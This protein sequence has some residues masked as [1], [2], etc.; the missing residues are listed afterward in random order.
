MNEAGATAVLAKAKKDLKV[1]ADALK[2]VTKADKEKKD[3]KEA[4]KKAADKKA[5]DEKAAADAKVADW[6]CE[7]CDHMNKADATKCAGCGAPRKK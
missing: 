4:D 2:T 5:A 1:A 6:K 3:A 7:Y